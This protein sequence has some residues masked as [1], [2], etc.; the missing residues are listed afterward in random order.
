MARPVKNNAEY[1]SHDADMRNDVRIK[2]VRKKFKAQ[3]YAIWNMVIEYLTDQDYF[4]FQF[5]EL[6]LEL[7]SGDFDEETQVIKDVVEYCVKLDLLQNEEGF[8]KC[9]PLKNVWNLC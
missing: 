3:G 7:L 2:A 4:K 5:D 6:T 9:K 8:I 1:F